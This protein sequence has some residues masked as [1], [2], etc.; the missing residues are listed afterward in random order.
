MEHILATCKPKIS[1]GFSTINPL[2]TS[3]NR[4]EYATPD[5]VPS[6]SKRPFN[7]F[8]RATR[9]LKGAPADEA[10]IEDHSGEENGGPWKPKIISSPSR[11]DASAEVLSA[12]AAT[13]IEGAVPVREIP[14]KL[15]SEPASMCPSEVS[16]QAGDLDFHADTKKR[17]ESFSVVDSHEEELRCVIAVIRHGDRTPKQKLKVNMKVSDRKDFI[18]K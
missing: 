13:L 15:L 14:N 16:S 4:I 10:E 17:S 6:S 5:Y 7:F 3:V 9:M 2:I 12:A 11:S 8:S 18:A 1:I